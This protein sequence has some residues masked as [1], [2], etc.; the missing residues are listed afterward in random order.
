MAQAV[1]VVRKSSVEDLLEQINS[2]SKYRTIY[3]IPCTNNPRLKQQALKVLL[4]EDLR[5]YIEAYDM[6][7][8]HNFYS[9]WL[10]GCIDTDGKAYI[11]R[12]IVEDDLE[13]DE[14]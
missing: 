11:V 5:K 13:D 1:T 7:M 14:W 3:F 9:V 10:E 12:L 8:E 6:L 2:L 4:V